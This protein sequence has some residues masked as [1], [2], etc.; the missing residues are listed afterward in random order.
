MTHDYVRGIDHV[1][2]TVPDIEA[3]TTFLIEAFGARVVYE[4]FTTDQPPQ[5]SPEID[6]DLNLHPGTRLVAARLVQLG[7]GPEIELFQL[8]AEVQRPASRPSDFGLQHLA[9]YVDDMAEALRCF[10]SAGGQMLSGPNPF[11]FPKEEGCG[12]LFCYGRTPWGMMVEFLTYPSG[13]GYERGTSLRRWH[14]C[15]S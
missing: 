1:G 15:G 3:A 11:L 4:S 14:S 2:V 12:N 5:G 7:R 8:Q 13:M 9:I 10:E 6:R